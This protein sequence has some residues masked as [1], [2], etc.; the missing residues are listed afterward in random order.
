MRHTGTR[1]QMES[2]EL[3]QMR[4]GPYWDK[5]DGSLRVPHRW[6]I[7]A[8]AKLFKDRGFQ[9]DAKRKEFWRKQAGDERR[10]KSCR[11]FFY[12]AYKL[13]D[14]RVTPLTA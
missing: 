2:Y 13:F 14:P 10:V 4:R 8:A 7:P 3:A 11:A 6:K 1:A 12:S 9:Y 5:H